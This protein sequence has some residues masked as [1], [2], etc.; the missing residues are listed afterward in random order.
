MVN[1]VTYCCCCDAKSEPS[2]TTT[3]TTTTTA[4]TT[5]A[6]AEF[7]PQGEAIWITD[8]HDMQRL[9]RQGFF[10][11]ATLSRS[12]ASWKSR[13]LEKIHGAASPNLSLEDITRKRRIERAAIKEEKR[14]A[15][16]NGSAAASGE[17]SPTAVM[18]T[19]TG[20]GAIAT[21]AAVT[22]TT[23]AATATAS[24]SPSSAMSPLTSS[25]S[26]SPMLLSPP[27]DSPT[28][29]SLDSIDDIEHLQ[30][31]L[32]EAFFLVFAVEAIAVYA[33]SSSSPSSSSSLSS[34]LSSTKGTAQQPMTIR[35]CWRR[36]AEASMVAG[37][38]SS[39]TTTTTTTTT[40]RTLLP[41]GWE[42]PFV[43]RYVAYHHFRSH[44]WVVKDGLKYGVDFLLYRKGVV[45][46][47]SEYAVKVIS[48]SPSSSTALETS[49]PLQLS[50]HPML[51]RVDPWHH[52]VYSW[53]WLLT[54]NRVV[55][56]VQKTLLLCH[57][58]PPQDP[59]SLPDHTLLDPRLALPQY[60]V[61]EL[62]SRRW[63]P[64]RHRA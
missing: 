63:I 40:A 24:S 29:P 36:F 8:P 5:L 30:L 57:V 18:A 27:P 38:P 19:A 2:T 26:A 23:T 11:K 41:S 17:G 46:G 3:I 62:T 60:T 43:V 28:D 31:S 1:Q 32:E 13:Q 14:L 47:H 59:S 55:S 20:T 64:E 53:Q 45:F 52:P 25:V 35:E 54:L 33:F 42:N 15:S 6:R 58:I 51:G 4:T 44:G 10:G 12:E 49:L 7:H 16:A 21:T 9:F 61:V 34:T 39:T 56:Q 22:T 37:V 48:G 50:P